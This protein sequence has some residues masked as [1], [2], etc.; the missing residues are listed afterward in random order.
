[1]T[2]EL[3]L[4]P[5]GLKGDVSLSVFFMF[6][7]VQSRRRKPLSSL[8]SIVLHQVEQEVGAVQELAVLEGIGGTAFLV[9]P[10]RSDLTGT[11]RQAEDTHNTSGP[12]RGMFL[13]LREVICFPTLNRPSVFSFLF[14]TCR[15]SG[16]FH[17]VFV[18]FAKR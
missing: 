16:D 15:E 12:K 3:L 7:N 9:L 18:G 1:M 13:A 5:P 2:Q 8:T 6:C 10:R 14:F 4:H 11:L 17:C